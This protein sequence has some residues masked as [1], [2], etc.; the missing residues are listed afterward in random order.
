MAIN[1][2]GGYSIPKLTYV[3]F[4]SIAIFQ[5]LLHLIIKMYL[6]QAD[7]QLYLGVCISGTNAALQQYENDIYL[8]GVPKTRKGVPW[9]VDDF[10]AMQHK[11]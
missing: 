9:G 2:F 4:T 8:I 11:I 3:Q 6:C 5:L 1:N 10:C 7:G